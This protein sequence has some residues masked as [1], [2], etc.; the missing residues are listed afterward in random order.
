MGRQVLSYAVENLQAY[1][2]S[3]ASLTGE[4]YQYLGPVALRQQSCQ[5]DPMT[6]CKIRFASRSLVLGSLRYRWSSVRTRRTRRYSYLVVISDW[7]WHL[8]GV[9]LPTVS[10]GWEQPTL[11]VSP[12]GW[13][14]KSRWE[15][16]EAPGLETL[17][18]HISSMLCK[19]PSSLS[20]TSRRQRRAKITLSWF[21]EF[22]HMTST[23]PINPT[24]TA[25]HRGTW[26]CAY[27]LKF[28][29]FV[30]PPGDGSSGSSGW[31]LQLQAMSHDVPRS[32]EFAVEVTGTVTL[33]GSL[34]L[35]EANGRCLVRALHALQ[36]IHVPWSC[37]KSS[38]EN[39][40]EFSRCSSWNSHQKHR[41]NRFM[42]CFF[43]TKS[44]QSSQS[45]PVIVPIS[46]H[47]FPGLRSW[48]PMRSTGNT[49]RAG[50]RWAGWVGWVGWGGTVE[51]KSS[52]TGRK[53]DR[54]HPM[55]FDTKSPFWETSTGIFMEFSWNK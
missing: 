7:G 5:Q 16:L 45:W 33:K 53:P 6:Y 9:Q 23:F 31:L 43:L 39:S 8:E 50:P 21:D 32:T 35:N 2:P 13:L 47:I 46:S 28:V 11:R 49:F 22:F 54:K 17:F 40:R 27:S 18:L 19:P 51:P 10:A 36:Q 15:G 48:T 30:E 52:S 20:E 55:F 12:A 3:L 24:G 14:N 1:L 34:F 26:G 38:D 44:W 25:Q 29:S 37:T 42:V 41:P 4:S